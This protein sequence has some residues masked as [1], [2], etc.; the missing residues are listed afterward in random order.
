MLAGADL[1]GADLRWVDLSEANLVRANLTGA[2]CY[3]ANLSRA[4]LYEASLAGA[5]LRSARL[6][7]GSIEV[8][9]PRSRSLPPRHSTGDHT[10]AV[11]EN[12]D[13]TGVEGMSEEQRVYCCAWCGERS[14]ATIPGGCDGIPNR[15]GR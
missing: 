2:D 9:T 15:L 1:A 14:R 5:N 11:V 6:F 8:A 10:G 13:F 4:V 12:T 3:R 7:Y